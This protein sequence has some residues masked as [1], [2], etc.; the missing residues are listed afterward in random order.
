[1]QF[2]K[3]FSMKIFGIC[4][5]VK[6]ISGLL[7]RHFCRQES[8]RITAESIQQQIPYYLSRAAKE[9]LA[10][11]LQGFPRRIDYYIDRYHDEVLQGDGWNSFVVVNID[12]GER[13]TI[14][15][16]LLTNSC[17]V[18]PENKREIPPTFTFA[19]IVRLEGYVKK[20]LAAGVTQRQIDDKVAAIKEQSVTNLFYLPKGAALDDDY[21]ALLGD[22][23]TVPLRVFHERHDRQ[24]LF[25]LSQTGF[26]LFVLKLSV[27]FCR[28]H[29]EVERC[30]T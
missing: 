22:V 21:V 10:K 9:N 24:K 20:L 17:D 7:L 13:K 8:Q 1:M 18:S 14:R 2:L 29:E 23:H 19:P 5:R 15:G 6:S 28:F 25:T 11:E 26:Y 3:K 12:N 30:P 16:I 27:H 4:T